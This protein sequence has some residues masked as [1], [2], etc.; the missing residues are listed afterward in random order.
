MTYAPSLEGLLDKADITEVI[1]AYCY[2]FDRADADA[3]AALFT[4]DALVDYGPDVDDLHGSAAL[5][6][7]VSRGTSTLFAATSHHVSNVSIRF[8]GPDQATSNC[9]VYAWH[10]Y[11]ETNEESELWGQYDHSFRRTPSGWRI[12]RLVL[13]AV[14]LR[15]FHRARMHP[16]PRG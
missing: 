2:H 6:D 14:G 8:D 15:N 13:S 3:V 5:R 4:E 16:I 10:R 1:H 12:S 11:L 9:Y 7:M